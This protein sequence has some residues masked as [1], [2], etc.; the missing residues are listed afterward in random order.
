MLCG[1]LIGGEEGGMEEQVDLPS[2]G[3]LEAECHLGDGFFDFKRTSL[4]H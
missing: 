1:L 2:R 3:D 4:L